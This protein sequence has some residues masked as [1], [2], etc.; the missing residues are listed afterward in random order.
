M[1]DVTNEST[2]VNL[3]EFAEM[4][5]FPVELVKKELMMDRNSTEEVSLGELRTAMLKYL[6]SAMLE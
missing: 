4:T 5:G 1:S 3:S 6:D 2:S